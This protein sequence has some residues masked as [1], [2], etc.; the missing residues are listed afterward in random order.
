M[1]FAAAISVMAVLAFAASAVAG[2]PPPTTRFVDDDGL[3]GANGC[4]GNNTVPRRIQGAINHANEGDTILV[5]PGSYTGF[6]IDEDA[7]HPDGLTVPASSRGRPGSSR[8][9]ANS[10]SS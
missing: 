6:L 10:T 4:D 8:T 9:P 7:D 1:G 3:A 5:C 2:Q